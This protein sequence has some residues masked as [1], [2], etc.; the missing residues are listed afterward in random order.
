MAY[1]GSESCTW[2]CELVLLGLGL[3]PKAQSLNGLSGSPSLQNMF[4][5]NAVKGNHII[6]GEF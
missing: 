3:Y 6:G 1:A 5:R 4:T 2:T